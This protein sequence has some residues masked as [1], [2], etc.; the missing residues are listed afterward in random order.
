MRSAIIGVCYGPDS[1]Q[2]RDLVRIS[3]RMTHV[4][5]KAEWAA[6]AVALAAGLA[7][8]GNVRPSSFQEELKDALGEEAS[9][10]LA[11][12]G[13]SAIS[14]ERGES[15]SQ[16][17][18]S[19]GFARGASG[20]C[21]ESVPVALH[22]WLAHQGNYRKTVLSAIECGGDTDTTAAIA[23][24]IAG[25]QV[26]VA[27]I[28]E[29]WVQCLS[30]WPRTSSWMQQLSRSVALAVESGKR[31]QPAGLPFFGLL[32]RNALF[33]AIVILHGFRRL[34]PPY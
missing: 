7:C 5:P 9:E 31:Q 18:L 8:Q 16:F 29:Q 4:D 30:A 15:T 24:A 11:L 21:L 13:A 10:F 6:F 23:G 19:L 3:T 26:G 1:T 25:T 20:Y 14:A 28:P 34:L 32:L 33:A 12:T 27:G 2:M 22:A 17:A